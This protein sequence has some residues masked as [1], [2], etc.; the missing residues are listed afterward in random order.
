ME[1]KM[2]TTTY[3]LVMS[4]FESHA[5]AILKLDPFDLHLRWD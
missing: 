5:A 1:S 4:I 3:F 2:L